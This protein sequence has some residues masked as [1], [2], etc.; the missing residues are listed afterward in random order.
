[1]DIAILI[2]QIVI[3]LGLGAAYLLIRSYLP[4]YFEEKGKN[5]ATKEDIEEITLKV[6]KVKAE[7]SRSQ[8]IFHAKYQLKHEAYLEALK[9]VDAHFSHTL[10][11]PD[12][13]QIVKQFATTEDARECHNKLI[14]ACENPDILEVFSEIMFGPEKKDAPITPPTDLLNRFRNLIRGELGFGVD[15]DL[16]CDR[17]WFARMGSELKGDKV[18]E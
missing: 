14:L 2:L 18:T 7:I 4:K 12:G 13:G 3:L 8:S 5:L 17:A 6:E 11:D 15:I 16:D 1:M 9:M 10:Q